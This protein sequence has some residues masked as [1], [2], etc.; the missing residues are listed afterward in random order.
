ME[1]DKG[2]G[3]NSTIS[4]STVSGDLEFDKA[5]EFEGKNYSKK[6]G[7]GKH[8][9]NVETVSGDFNLDL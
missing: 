2:Q 8:K 4:F 1:I 6:F 7:T 9:L 3:N 5:A